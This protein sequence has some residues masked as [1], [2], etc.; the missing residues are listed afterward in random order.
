M[1]NEKAETGCNSDVAVPTD[2]QMN[3]RNANEVPATPAV[4][5]WTSDFLLPSISFREPKRS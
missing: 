2:K 1:S 4:L 5:P 3:E